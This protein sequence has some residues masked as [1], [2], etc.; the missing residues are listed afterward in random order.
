[1]P[2]EDALS[3]L[4]DRVE[5]FANIAKGLP[6]NLQAICFELLLRNFLEATPIYQTEA[7]ESEDRVKH[8]LTR[9]G[10]LSWKAILVTGAGVRKARRRNN[11]P[12]SRSRDR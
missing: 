12:L 11:R 2:W 6:D 1:V 9:V 4:K 3:K 8:E 10:A 5:E 7:F